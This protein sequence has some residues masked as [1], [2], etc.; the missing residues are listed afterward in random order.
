M[1]RTA[2]EFLKK[3][4]RTD[5]A[6]GGGLNFENARGEGD[7]KGAKG[8]FEGIPIHG[9]DALVLSEATVAA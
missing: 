5:V 1:N 6:G 9:T 2:K 3:Q 4:S 7:A 8:S